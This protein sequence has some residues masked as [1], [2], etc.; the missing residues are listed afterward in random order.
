VSDVKLSEDLAKAFRANPDAEGILDEEAARRLAESFPSFPEEQVK[1]GAGWERSTRV[2]SRFGDLESVEKTMYA[3]LETK[4]GRE[5]HKLE[6]KSS[7]RF[8]LTAKETPGVKLE[9]EESAASATFDAE[10][11]HI[12]EAVQARK[13]HLQIGGVPGRRSYDSTTETTVTSRLK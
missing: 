2:P 6:I 11:G 5:L 4:A 12:D 3:G 1:V 9:P 10:A 8:A 7:F 13:L